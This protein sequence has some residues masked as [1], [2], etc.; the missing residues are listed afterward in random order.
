VWRVSTNGQRDEQQESVE[1]SYEGMD[2]LH[3]L[4]SGAGVLASL[5]PYDETILDDQELA[6]VI[7]ELEDMVRVIDDDIA[8]SALVDFVRYLRESEALGLSVCFCGD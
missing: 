3:R 8:K 5:D 2:V 7:R 1:L 6:E 4:K